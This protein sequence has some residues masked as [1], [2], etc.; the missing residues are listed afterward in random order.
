MTNRP[1]AEIATDIFILINALIWLV[2]GIM[3]AFNTIPGLPDIPM[4]KW[5]FAFLSFIMA[6]IILVLFIFLTRRN[7]RAYYLTLAIFIFTAVL[8]IFDDVGWSD[9]VV[10]ALNIVP[11][12]LLIINRA[13]YLQTNPQIKQTG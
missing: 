4:I 11:I 1:L 6:C 13:W 3:I 2:L 10:L 8:T 12:V 9:V 7:R 5:I